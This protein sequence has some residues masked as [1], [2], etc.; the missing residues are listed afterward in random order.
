MRFL[1]CK[2]V[3]KN[4]GDGFGVGEGNQL[5]VLGDILPIVHKHSLDMIGN[6]KIDHR[7]AMESILLV[8]RLEDVSKYYGQSKRGVSE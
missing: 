4:L 7:L 8:E 2:V 6:R 1:M 5:V 3:L